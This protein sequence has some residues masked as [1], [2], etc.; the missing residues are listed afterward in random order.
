MDALDD[1][2]ID[3]TP[4]TS[5]EMRL[6]K[7]Y[8]GTSTK[9]KK[10]FHEFKLILIATFLFAILSTSYFDTM[11]EY[12]PYST[13]NSNFAKLGLKLFIFALFFYILIILFS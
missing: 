7:K 13:N 2:P 8:L 6:L 1:L 11:L 3:N 10:F 4:A 5:N 9:N 12:F